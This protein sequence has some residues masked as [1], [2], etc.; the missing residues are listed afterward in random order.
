MKTA[1]RAPWIP[2][3]RIEP[4]V[5][6]EPILLLGLGLVVLWALYLGA[7]RRVS[8][9]RHQMLRG[10]LAN[11]SL[12]CAVFAGLAVGYFGFDLDPIE[13]SQLVRVQPWL[14]LIVLVQGCIVFTK[15]SKVLAM[16]LL[17]L[18]HMREFVP[19]LLIN[20]MTA[21]VSLVSFG[22][23]AASVFDLQ[24]G[25]LLATSAAASVVLGL[26]M[27]DT[28]G[29]LFAGIAMQ[30]DKPYEIGDWIEVTAGL[31]KWNG[32]VWEVTWRATAL[33]G[34]AG[35]LI[36]IPNRVVGQGQ[37]VNYSQR[38]VPVARELLLMLDLSC[39]LEK[40]RGELQRALARVPGVVA[41][42][43]PEV[44]FS[45]VVEAQVKARLVYWLRDLP[46][47]PQ[48]A[49]AA[50]TAALAAVRQQATLEKN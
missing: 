2:L 38:D 10:A 18:S 9:E 11:L 20:T 19:A 43:A 39:D 33:T 4:L 48:I 17:F 15:G 34:V 30:F 24:I 41:Q 31:Y 27:Q 7:M 1:V 49:D 32:Q 8:V 23:L 22:W 36:S 47:Q 12:H 46:H 44:L 5:Q 28:L 50:I 35:E 6:P 29:N 21:L 40:M 25:P 13:Q 42:P 37:V 26:A 14:G 16:E 3:Q 45:E